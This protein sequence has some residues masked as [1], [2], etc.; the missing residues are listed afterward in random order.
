MSQALPFHPSPKSVPPRA[1]VIDFRVSIHYNSYTQTLR[2]RI[3][4]THIHDCLLEWLPDNER[5]DKLST[6]FLTLAE[7]KYLKRRVGSSTSSSLFGFV[8][9]GNHSYQHTRGSQ[10]FA[11]AAQ[12]N[13][14]SDSI[15]S[16]V[17]PLPFRAQHATHLMGSY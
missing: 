3:M 2:V 7:F 16:T 15:P 9:P 12:R 8:Y 14:T 10:G 1:L 17:S 4:P 11:G 5:V 13:T 6:G